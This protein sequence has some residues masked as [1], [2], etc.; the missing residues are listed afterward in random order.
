[1]A[2][3]S[4]GASAIE[5][6]GAVVIGRLSLARLALDY[7]GA[8]GAPFFDLDSL[9]AV[10]RPRALSATLRGSVEALPLAISVRG[11][12]LTGLVA[13]AGARPGDDAPAWPLGLSLTFLGS[14]VQAE[15]SVSRAR[16]VWNGEFDV[17][18]GTPDLVEFERLFA[19]PLPRAGA[20]A[21]AGRLSVSPGNVALRGL[22]ASI[23][24]SSLTGDLALTLAGTRP[25]LTG[26]LAL[27]ALDLRPFLEQDASTAPEPARS[28]A[29]WYR[30]IGQALRWPSCAASTP[31]DLSVALAEP[32]RRCARCL[33][34][35]G[36]M[37]DA[38]RRPCTR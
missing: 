26:A 29:Q 21:L 7:T 35:F 30:E 24:Q 14:A 9:E 17:G 3:A 34:G 33:G 23:G 4:G 2:P 16:G 12:A 18:L 1:V 28:L 11:G 19:R 31:L 27:A 5:L 32:A 6:P 25:R 38:W 22:S 8:D 36:W 15:G 13:L 10:R 37:T 20:A